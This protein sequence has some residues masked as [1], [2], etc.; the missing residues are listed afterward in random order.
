VSAHEQFAE[1][2]DGGIALASQRDRVQP[3]SLRVKAQQNS[4]PIPFYDARSSSALGMRQ[5]GLKRTLDLLIA[6]PLIVILAPPLALIALLIVLDSPGPAVF[7]QRRLGLSGRPFDIFKFRTMYVLENGDNVA[8]V[9]RNDPRVTRFGRW[10]RRTSIDEL[11][12]LFNVVRGEMSLV[13]P[14]PHAV[15]HDRHFGALI[16]SYELRQRAKPGIT[17]W[18]QIHDLR[19][20]TPTLE[21]MRLRV[22]YD[23]WY[24]RH[25]NFPLDL[26]ILL[27]TLRE[28]LRQRNSY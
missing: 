7:R 28:L 11:P 3:A 26:Q 17:G 14:R 24:A 12:Q 16:E 4:D 20:E 5:P 15:V 1:L 25:A 6:V 13:G 8:Q 27:R 22:L 10:L 19:G 23:N 21:A 9:C 18:A 2:A